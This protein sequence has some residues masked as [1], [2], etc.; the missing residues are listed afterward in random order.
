MLTERPHGIQKGK[1]NMD[2]MTAREVDRLAD[3]LRPQGFAA[4]QVLERVKY[5]SGTSEPSRD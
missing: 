5:I 3:W 4:E 1:M 2:E